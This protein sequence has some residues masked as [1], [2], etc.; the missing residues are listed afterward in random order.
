MKNCPNNVTP[1]VGQNVELGVGVHQIA[2][3]GGTVIPFT[4][5]SGTFAIIRSEIEGQMVDALK[6]VSVGT[7]YFNANDLG[8][9]STEAR[10]NTIDVW[11]HKQATTFNRFVMTNDPTGALGDDG[12]LIQTDDTERF[13]IFRITNGGI[14][15]T[16]M[17]S[18][19]DEV[20][21]NTWFNVRVEATNAGVYTAWI[22]NV[23]ADSSASG[24]NPTGAD[25]TYT[26]APYIKFNMGT[27]DRVALFKKY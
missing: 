14:G 16:R 27:G 8:Q 11:L 25:N 15:S 5:Q 9:N 10:Y 3:N 2:F 4:V 24:S 18:A 22:D 23:L 6:C 17:R 19:V 12:Y 20:P 7:G 13:V 26:V 1:N 21:V